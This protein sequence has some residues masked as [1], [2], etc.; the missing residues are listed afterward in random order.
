MLESLFIKVTG[1]KACNF[2]KKRHRHTCFPAKFA[3]FLRTFI[4]KNICERLLL[5]CDTIKKHLGLPVD[6]Y[7]AECS[8]IYN[9]DFVFIFGFLRVFSHSS[10]EKNG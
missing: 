8:S 10:E 5:T 2:F 6:S 3:E 9:N 4:S 1:L 7:L